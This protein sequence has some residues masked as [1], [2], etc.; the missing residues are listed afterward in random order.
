M[1]TVKNELVL[2]WTASYVLFGVFSSVRKTYPT[3]LAAGPIFIF[4]SKV[5][6]VRLSKLFNILANSLVLCQREQSKI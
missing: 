4:A 2:T 1:C 6:S 3:D 5:N